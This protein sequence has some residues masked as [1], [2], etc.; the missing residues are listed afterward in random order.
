MI[1]RQYYGSLI[2]LTM[3]TYLRMVSQGQKWCMIN[4]W[5]RNNM[6]AS[7]GCLNRIY[8]SAEG[9]IRRKE[10]FIWE[11]YFSTY[12]MGNI[13]KKRKGGGWTEIERMWYVVTFECSDSFNR[14]TFFKPRNLA[15]RFRRENWCFR[16]LYLRESVWKSSNGFRCTVIYR[17]P[18]FELATRFSNA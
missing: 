15:K 2:C 13:K 5:Q 16:P 6:R 8:C 1:R 4:R 9:K 10:R 3:S 11:L 18:F 17:T 12:V 7:F 14:R